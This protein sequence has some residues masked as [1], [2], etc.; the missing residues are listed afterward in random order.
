MIAK[1]KT[2]NS[3]ARSS[4]S[5]PSHLIYLLFFLRMGDK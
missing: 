3:I 5:K 1:K 2:D 4:R